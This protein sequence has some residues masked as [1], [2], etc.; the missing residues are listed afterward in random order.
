MIKIEQYLQLNNSDKNSD[1][2]TNITILII[3]AKFNS[4]RDMWDEWPRLLKITAVM[5]IRPNFITYKLLGIY[6]K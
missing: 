5:V 1:K 4:I 2:N 6:T 3:L